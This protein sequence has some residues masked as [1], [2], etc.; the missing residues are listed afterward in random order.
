MAAAM[1]G[2]PLLKATGLWL[3]TSARGS[4]YLVGR[5]GGLKILVMTN[6]DKVADEDPSHILY[7]RCGGRAPVTG[8]SPYFSTQDGGVRPAV[9][10]A[11]AAV[12]A[13]EGTFAE[14]G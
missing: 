8:P 12:F 7:P 1:T 4:E 14:L 6:R 11:A 10:P 9:G 3:R 13:L 5:L 2:S